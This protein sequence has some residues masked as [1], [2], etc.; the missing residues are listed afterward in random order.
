ML[1]CLQFLSVV[2]KYTNIYLSS[3]E[4]PYYSASLVQESIESEFRTIEDFR[5]CRIPAKDVC[6]PG[7]GAVENFWKDAVASRFVFTFFPIIR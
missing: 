4:R 6:I 3:V 2:V 1:R 5:S 7:G